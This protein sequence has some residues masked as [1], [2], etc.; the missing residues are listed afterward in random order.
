MTRH[1]NVRQL[2]WLPGNGQLL[3]VGGKDQTVRL[4]QGATATEMATLFDY[5][6]YGL[7]TAVQWSPKNGRLA[8]GNDNGTVQIW[9]PE[10]GQ[11]VAVLGGHEGGITSLAWS[12]DGNWLA[13][14]GESDNDVRVWEAATG[15]L[16]AV[17]AKHTAEVTAVS[18]SADSTQL[19]STGFDSVLLIWDVAQAEQA[20]L[21]RV[22]TLG[23]ALA[24]AWSPDGAK[25]VVSGQTG[26]VQIRPPDINE[27]TVTI[28]E[29]GQP[30][31]ALAWASDSSRFASGDNG[32]E[33]LVWETAVT[34]N[35]NPLLTIAGGGSIRHLAW[36][37]DNTL[38]AATSGPTVRFYDT[39]GGTLLHTL[40]NQHPFSGNASWSA[41]GK[42]L[43]TI[44]ADGLV[45]LWQV[46]AAPIN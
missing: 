44:G 15:E 27:R 26:L 42:H 10:T 6:S 18:W 5:A 41:D 28:N 13:T 24:I 29:R 17:L 40:E 1:A 20:N 46:L 37:P 2:F 33:L 4:W 22:S 16:A 43:A 39:A 32:G 23:P 30:V 19:A 7:G 9:S 35:G 3:S 38:L 34:D 45:Q 8:V 36:S 12:P 14:S 31:P 25:I 21:Y 11:I